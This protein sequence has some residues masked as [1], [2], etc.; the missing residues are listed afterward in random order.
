MPY[1]K[2]IQTRTGNFAL[3]YLDGN[4][5]GLCQSVRGQVGF[6][7]QPVYEIGNIDPVENVPTRGVYSCTVRKVT[8]LRNDPLVALIPINGEDALKALVFDIEVYDKRED[9]PASLLKKWIAC[10]YDSGTIS[11]DAN[12]ITIKDASFR[13]L[14]VAG[15]GL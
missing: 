4:V 1:P 7:V 5:V 9:G 15:A 12:Q 11:V 14:G 6:T 10:T 2:P 13:A 3:V 8:L